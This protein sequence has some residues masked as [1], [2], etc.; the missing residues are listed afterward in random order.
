MSVKEIDVI[1]IEAPW[2]A[3]PFRPVAALD[4]EQEPKAPGGEAGGG[5]GLGTV[6]I[7]LASAP[8]PEELDSHG[9][10]VTIYVP[11]V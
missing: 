10:S 7:E 1:R 5:G 11:L 4:Q 6:R 8:S 2:L 9:K 3:L